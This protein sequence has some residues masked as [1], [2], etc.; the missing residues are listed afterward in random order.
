MYMIIKADSYKPKM[1]YCLILVLCAGNRN[2]TVPQVI[3]IA[4]STRQF[5]SNDKRQ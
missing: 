4:A 2:N 5:I 3:N 1:R